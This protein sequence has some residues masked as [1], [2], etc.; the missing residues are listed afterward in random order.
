[1]LALLWLCLIA[2]PVYGKAHVGINGEKA[3]QTTTDTSRF[4]Q[5]LAKLHEP[6]SGQVMICAHRGIKDRFPENSISGLTKCVEMGIEIVEID[7]RK[8]KDGKLVVIHDKTL[9]RTTTGSGSVSEYTLEELKHLYLLDINGN[10]TNE[11]IPTLEEVLDVAK[12]KI[13]LQVDKWQESKDEIL[14]VLEKKECLQQ[15]IFRSTSPYETVRATFND[16]LDKIIYIPV[17]VIDRPTAQSTLD[18]FLQNMPD[19]PVVSIIFPDEELPMLDQVPQLRK[20][21]R[22]WYNAI[23]PTQCG[24]RDDSF[25]ET[26]PDDSYGWLVDNGGDIIFTTRPVEL[27]DYL[28]SIHKR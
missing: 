10:V 2:V 26:N 22:I 1:M 6:E 12:N 16:Y 11:K 21:Y 17:I 28:Q 24:G 23:N 25:A 7:I 19:M 4:A 3:K 5:L 27:D 13:L 20:K 9:D 18:G 8:T 15:A 14:A